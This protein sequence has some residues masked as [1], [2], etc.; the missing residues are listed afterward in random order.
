MKKYKRYKCKECN[1]TIDVPLETMEMNEQIN[2]GV[3][4]DLNSVCMHCR[5]AFSK[6]T[7]GRL[8]D[9]KQFATL[10]LLPGILVKDENGNIIEGKK[11]D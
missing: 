2:K 10:E 3:G 11:D 7:E 4:F 1:K 6:E 8:F 9:L 5:L